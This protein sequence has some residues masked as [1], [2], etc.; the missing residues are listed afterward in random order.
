MA[1]VQAILWVHQP[2][3]NGT[4]PIR[5]RI[6]KDRRSS[7]KAIGY[8]VKEADWDKRQGK[9][10]K[11]HPNSVRLNNLIT[12]RILEAQS[13]SIELE[14]KE[15]TVSVK[16]ITIKLK[17]KGGA[18][19]FAFAET[20]MVKFNNDDRYGTYNSYQTAISKLRQF[21][22]RSTITFNEIDYRLLQDF[23]AYLIRIGNNPNTRAQKFK[24]IKTIYRE[25]IRA[26]LA[27]RDK[28]PFE[29]FKLESNKSHKEKLTTEELNVIRGLPLDEDSNL[30]HARNIFIFM[31][32]MCG[33]RFGDALLLKKRN[34][35]QGRLYYEMDKTADLMSIRLTEEATEILKHYKLHEM[36]DDDYIFPF[37][38]INPRA[39]RHR[40]VH[41]ANAMTNKYLRELI[42]L[43]CIDKHISTH[44]ARHSW[45]QLAKTKMVET[46]IIQQAFGHASPKTTEIYMDSFA[47]TV[48]DDANKLVTGN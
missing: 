37:A 10:K 21:L 30:W 44:C 24:K 6:T 27:D 33:M 32:N 1:T 42:S 14:T 11:S 16:R 25:A 13:A 22:G 15:P 19:F 40:I 34:I 18:D 38:N 43:A 41:S 4:C 3:K 23:R 2:L 7:Y 35:R 9:V 45:A 8:S 46:S 31:F 5:L 12:Q 29:E 36:N 47:D 26:G 28:Y 48:I 39:K 17:H 20:H